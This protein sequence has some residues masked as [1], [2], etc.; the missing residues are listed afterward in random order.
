VPEQE[1]IGSFPKISHLSGGFAAG[2]LNTNLP[3]TLKESKTGRKHSTRSP[4]GA[5][6]SVHFVNSDFVIGVNLT[7]SR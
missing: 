2:S 7:E 6:S 4:V 1:N 3:K 5:S